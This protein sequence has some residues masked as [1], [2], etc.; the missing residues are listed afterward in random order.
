MLRRE[1]LFA[2]GGFIAQKVATD[3]YLYKFKCKIQC[4]EKTII[5]KRLGVVQTPFSSP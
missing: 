3:A 1:S 4:A 5:V 2:A